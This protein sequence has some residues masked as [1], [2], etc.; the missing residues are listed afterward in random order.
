MNVAELIYEKAK[1]LPDDLQSE[2]LGFMEYLSRRPK[3]GVEAAEW[4]RVFRQIQELSQAKGVSD[5][6]IAAEVAA[7]RSRK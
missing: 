1:S 6:E 2:A 3:A 7:Y 4:E 5:E